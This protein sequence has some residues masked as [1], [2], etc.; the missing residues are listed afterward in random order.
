MKV[1]LRKKNKRYCRECNKILPASN[2]NYCSKCK[3]LLFGENEED[4]PYQSA[5]K[6]SLSQK[7]IE[8]Y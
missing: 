8:I 3:N 2:W 7:F 4:F 6:L 5:Y 1:L